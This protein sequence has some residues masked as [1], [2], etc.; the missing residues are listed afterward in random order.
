VA[1]TLWTVV[2]LGLDLAGPAAR[3]TPLQRTTQPSG[4]PPAGPIPVQV[5]PTPV[6]GFSPE[7]PLPGELGVVG[8][9]TTTTGAGNPGAGGGNGGSNP[10]ATQPGIEEG[11]GPLPNADARVSLRANEEDVRQVLALLGR[12]A[13]VNILVSPA[14]R[15]AVQID[16]ENVTFRQALEA[17]LKLASLAARQ[18]SGLVYVYSLGEF[19][20]LRG[21]ERRPQVRV[22]HLNYVRAEDLQLMITP[23]LSDIGA[24]TTTPAAAMGLGGGAA[25]LGGG[26]GGGGGGMG[27]GGGGGGMGGGG[28]ATA[29]GGSSNGVDTGGN[30]MAYHDIV[31]V[32]DYPDNLQVIDEI[33]RRVDVQ[34]PQVL[35]EAVILSVRLRDEQELGVN[36]SIV[37]N[38]EKLAA[39]QG[40]AGAINA[41]AGFSPARVLAA[42]VTRPGPGQLAPGYVFPQSPL[43]GLKF[44]F[45][46]NNVSG[47][48]RAVETFN[49]VNIL[50]SPR[51]LVLN[52]QRAEIQ[53]GQRLGFRNTV[54][55]LTSSLQTVEFL[56]VGTLLTLRP[57]VSNDGMI[58]LEIHP[59]KSTGA[60]DSQGIP[61][62]NTSE[63]TTNILV[64]DGATIVIGGLIDDDDTVNEQGTPGLNRLPLVGALF[65]SRNT[66]SAKNELIVLLTPRVLR[67]GGLPEPMPGVAPKGVLGLPNSGPMP[68]PATGLPGGGLADG[69]GLPL[70]G[71]LLAPP[72]TFRVG[73]GAGVG[74]TIGPADLPPLP[75]S[76]ASP[77]ADPAPSP[78]P[79]TPTPAA[80]EPPTPTPPTPA[81]PPPPG[82]VTPP[83]SALEASRT[84]APPGRLATAPTVTDGP[85]ARD[86][87]ARPASLEAAV[88][89]PAP[90][91]APPAPPTASGPPGGWSH[92]VK[93]GE[94]FMSIA[95]AYY[96]TPGFHRALWAANR[97]AVPRYDGLR[98]GQRLVVPPAGALDIAAGELPSPLTARERGRT[99]TPRLAPPSG[100]KAAER[101]SR[102]W[103]GSG[104]FR[105]KPAGGGDSGADDG[106]AAPAPRRR[107]WA[108]PS[109]GAVHDAPPA[110]A[111]TPRADDPPYRL[112]DAAR[113][114]MRR[115][116]PRGFAPE[117]RLEDLAELNGPGRSPVASEPGPA[118]PAP[119]PAPG[120]SLVAGRAGLSGAEGLPAV[121]FLE[122]YY[123][124]SGPTPTTLL[125]TPRFSPDPAPPALG[126]ADSRPAPR[127]AAVGQ[128]SFEAPAPVHRL[129]SP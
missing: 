39:V 20:A 87:A 22:Y 82:D 38:L 9:P 56:S 58:R 30:T 28:G 59:E 4:L 44:G 75:A 125:A 61:Q 42:D 12:Q 52:K 79:P 85:A 103:P 83:A 115:L 29:G 126:L 60:L 121:T 43:Q 21:R 69:S 46:S 70:S 129:Q 118:A 106:P 63:L 53:L 27:G 45:I 23:F 54:T 119:P 68:G 3:A 84:A 78:A 111:T 2:A 74:T 112:G 10:P 105:R 11:S 127:D 51:V 73:D 1:V 76:G 110:V 91:P 95:Q 26:G 31:I 89:A 93:F 92:T 25:G 120:G 116:R 123:R 66:A 18:E 5:M 7:G 57:Y 109:L 77:F 49:K 62:T 16:L 96:G 72:P 99:P 41:A 81:P 55:N 71:P 35:I 107:G 13:A 47:F 32:R 17:V 113:G 6:P 122:A 117:L 14:V 128:A 101:P 19:D 97:A 64:P 100:A 98:A 33:V 48:I 67:Q 86:P 102:S 80:T 40:N 24:T 36:F 15:G 50:A 124:P 114:M 104:L 37:D 108:T 34:P 94:T 88:V 90:P 8:L 65:R